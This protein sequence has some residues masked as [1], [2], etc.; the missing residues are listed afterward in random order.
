M[1]PTLR[2]AL[3]LLLLIST[4][5]VGCQEPM[6]QVSTISKFRVLAVQADPPEAAPGETVTHRVLYAD[7]EGEGR[8]VSVIWAT[9]LG[10][11]SPSSDLSGGC[12]ILGFSMDDAAAGG[13]VYETFSIPNEALD[14]IDTD[15][16]ETY[17]Q[18]TTIVSLC[19]GGERPDLSTIL[20]DESFSISSLDELCIGGDSLVA[21]KTFRISAEETPDRN[22]NPK[23][24]FVLFNG[25]RL[26]PVDPETGDILAPALT[27]DESA[28]KCDETDGCTE[29]EAAKVGRFVC[30][31][32]SECLDGVPVRAY[33]TDESFEVYEEIRSDT[34]EQLEDAPWLSWFID[35]GEMSVN[36][37]RTAEPPG[38]FKATWTPPQKG[39]SFTL[40]VV[41]HDLRGG[42]A[43]QQF[44][45]EAV[46]GISE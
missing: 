28:E 11:F 39:G 6:E 22:T 5:A 33:L 30:E 19:A 2:C 40:Y 8:D 43:W 31:T 13:N 41:A 35:G 29:G 26:Y 27:T 45:V 37:S 17:T 4:V 10:Y 20:T 15:N 16:G 46:T 44:A 1:K 7:P 12:E 38:P 21:F 9:C 42:T 14:L 34:P 32:T 18:A 25:N 36:M 3:T 24:D 23:I